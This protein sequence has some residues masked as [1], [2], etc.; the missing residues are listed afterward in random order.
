MEET[1]ATTP[2]RAEPS[3][4]APAEASAGE[5]VTEATT[6]QTAAVPAGSEPDATGDQTEAVVETASTATGPE[7]AVLGTD[8]CDGEAEGA[9]AGEGQAQDDA[10]LGQEHEV[11]PATGAQ[12]QEPAA[13]ATATAADEPEDQSYGQEQSQSTAVEHGEA[14]GPE[15]TYTSGLFGT[16]SMPPPPPPGSVD[17]L[18]EILETCRMLEAKERGLG[19]CAERAGSR[20]VAANGAPRPTCGLAHH[21]FRPS[22]PNWGSA[23]A[24]K[25]DLV[26]YH[27]MRHPLHAGRKYLKEA[28]AA[29]QEPKKTT[30][31]GDSSS[32]LGAE[33]CRDSSA[34]VTE[35]HH[36]VDV[37]GAAEFLF[38]MNGAP[39]SDCCDDEAGESRLEY[40]APEDGGAWEE[41]KADDGEKAKL[42]WEETQAMQEAEA[43]LAAANA[44]EQGRPR[45]VRFRTL[46]KA[47]ARATGLR[48]IFAKPTAAAKPSSAK[49]SSEQQLAQL[50]TEA[51]AAA[52]KAQGP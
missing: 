5:A 20:L 38:C 30:L 25:L 3:S 26:S 47:S 39:P 48:G 41:G 28:I 9:G 51:E 13:T 50:K 35:N 33:R 45:N 31:C 37:V 16:P 24:L 32:M 42:F 6:E 43:E 23:T 52:P 40:E 4:T 8:E 27:P 17:G 44:A 12:D 18:Q 19:A 7:E 10:A 36:D 49:L 29:R 46:R 2:A 22:T 21:A 1:T 15:A 34:M 11:V 14:E